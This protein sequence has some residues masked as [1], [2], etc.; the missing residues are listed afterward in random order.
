MFPWCGWQ[1]H[2]QKKVFVEDSYKK[3]TWSFKQ[4][5]L[6]PDTFSDNLGGLHI[7]DTRV[8]K[9]YTYNTAQVASFDGYMC[10]K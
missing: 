8:Q 1:V 9:Q 10:L 3:M 6:P 5:T 4:A 7:V 2:F